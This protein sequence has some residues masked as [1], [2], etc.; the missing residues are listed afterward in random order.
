MARTLKSNEMLSGR[1]FQVLEVPLCHE[2]RQKMIITTLKKVD[3]NEKFWDSDEQINL[4][5]EQLDKLFRSAIFGE[6]TQRPFGC[7]RP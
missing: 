1:R 2:G 7:L 4:R 5:N 6:A 3:W